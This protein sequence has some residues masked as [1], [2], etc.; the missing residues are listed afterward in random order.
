[1]GKNV[2]VIGTQWGDEGKGK[3][4]DL[5]TDKAD[6]VVRFQG[7]HNAGHTLVIDGKQTVLHLIPS[8]ILREGV[9]CLI[10]NGVVLSPEALLK[11]LA[12]LEEA[13]VEARSRIGLSESSTLILPYHVALDQAR[14]IARGKKAIG[15][16]G[17][18]IGPAYE[19][20]ISRRGIRLGEMMDADHFAE[21]LREVMDYHN[22]SLKH[23]YKQPDVDYREVLDEALG[24]A[25]QLRDLVEDVTGTLIR[26]RKEGKSVMYEGAQGALLDIDHGTY[27][28]VTSSNTTAGGAAT[29]TGTGP[30]ELDYVLGIVK[31]YT[32]RVGA[33]PFPTELFDEDGPGNHLGGKGHEFGA[34]TGRKRRCGWLNTVALRRSLA[35]N[36]VS[37]LCITKLDVL[38][39]L[40]TLKICVA[41]EFEGQEI[42][43]PPAGADNFEKCKPVYIKM[44]GWQDTT[45][46]AT[47]F[48][49]LPEA[50]RNYL[51]KLEEL[52]GT[53]IHIVSTG[54]DRDETLV[55]QHPFDS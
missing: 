3:I 25:E 48:D 52:C 11:E 44:P 30:R 38:D 16:T 41:Y 7:G 45:R 8:G 19:D 29:G 40:E 54:P 10:G 21:R 28:Y 20:K 43:Y 23:L 12:E 36:S 13:G 53:P 50:A 14:E 26:M 34:T 15:T 27:P 35:I 49:E 47:T 6:A 51:R 31:A 33:G 37:G 17:R 32:T 9:R 24:Q 1:M 18:G 2:V 22:F 46:E 5:L 55:L 39:G 42:D 4:V